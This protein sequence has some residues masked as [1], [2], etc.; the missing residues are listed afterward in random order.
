MTVKLNETGVSH[1]KSLIS[2]GSVDKTSSWSFSAE[3]GDKILG[4]NNW[5]EYAKWFLGEDTSATTKTKDRYKY[6]YGKNGKVY[7][8]GVI[9]AEQRAAAQGESGIADAAKS[10]LESIDKEK[11]SIETEEIEREF[12]GGWITREQAE[13]P[14]PNEHA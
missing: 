3:D 9:A 5:G 14:Y 7:R 11:K 8:S 13:R 12:E 2:S 6:P 10:L 4:D 1:A